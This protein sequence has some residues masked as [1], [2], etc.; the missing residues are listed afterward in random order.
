MHHRPMKSSGDQL[1]DPRVD[2]K[3]SHFDEEMSLDLILEQSLSKQLAARFVNQMI[4]AA[5]E[6]S[7]ERLL[8]RDRGV[9]KVNRPRQISMYLMN[10]A[11]SLKFTEIAEF[12][13]KDR[14]TV[15]HACRVIEEMRDNVEFDMRILEF[16]NTI[17]TALQLISGGI[18]RRQNGGL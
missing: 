11:L 16:E 6:I 17:N 18:T 4:A 7:G 3:L 5:Y 9:I 12:Y 10:T 1:F 8:R 13:D 2:R 15:S 14:T